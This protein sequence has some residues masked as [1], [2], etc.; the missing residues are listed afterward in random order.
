MT[1]EKKFT[2]VSI[3]R[4]L[5][6]KLK[7]RIEGT[8]FPS[9]SSYVAYVLSRVISKDEKENHPPREARKG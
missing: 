4:E 9:V 7:D 1:K 2:S 8:N 3:P 6:K 5:F